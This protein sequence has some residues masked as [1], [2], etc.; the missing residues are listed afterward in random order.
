MWFANLLYD[1]TSVAQS[2]FVVSVA[3]AL[4]LG[5]GNLTYKG[6]GLGIA[7]CLFSGLLMGHLGF[8]VN[9]EFLEFMREFGLILFVYTVGLQVG[10]G[11]LSA[12]RAQ[13]LRLNL[14]AAA[15][16][17]IGSFVTWVI[18]T[19]NDMPAAIAVG[20]FSGATT[21]TPS[22]GAAQSLL[23][24][25]LGPQNPSIQSSGMAYAVAYPFGVIGIIIVM[26]GLRIVFR[27]N[28]D[29]EAEAYGTD[30]R[31]ITEPLDIINIEVMNHNLNGLALDK[32]PGIEDLGVVISRVMSR[33]S[34]AGAG[35]ANCA[36]SVQ[37][38][39]AGVV[40]HEGDI[41]HAVGT[42]KNL[43]QLE[44]IVGRKTDID[45]KAF[46]SGYTS[47]RISIS[48]TSIAG[49]PIDDLG[50]VR[51]GGAVFTRINRA[52]LEFTPTSNVRL[53]FGDVVT[54]VGSE[55]ILRDTENELGNS[56]K[57]LGHPKILP[58]FIGIAI[59]V[60]IGSI[61]FAIPGSP[62]PIK[63]G[64]AG[65][66][67]LVAILFSI[68]RHLG[69][70]VWHLPQ[71]SNL[72]LRE[73]GIVLFLT[74]VGIKSGG[75]FIS[76][77]MTGP[78]LEWMGWGAIITL[79]PLVIVAVFARVALKMNFLVICGLVAGAST[80]PPAL[81]FANTQGQSDAPSL[82]YSTV[83]PLAMILR[84]FCAQALVLLLR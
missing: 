61:P 11:F 78:G 57:E 17:L 16:V 62:I 19:L 73:M 72:V 25:I 32:I 82:T 23:K 52:G 44:L 46:D 26:L 13:G 77:L 7:G 66:P 33:A 41:I 6:I 81:S 71:S 35:G 63:L 3:A 39:S 9:P 74:S 80:D 24:D 70:V 1:S 51:R 48:K 5:L 49:K 69:P 34:G 29:H 40:I 22:L 2:V 20:L 10:P 15:I 54:V 55:A 58:I 38:A 45:V 67:L 59:G 84:V 75:S 18:G 30:R 60:L 65:G 56:V 4:G 64:L 79:A 50:S 42:P 12:L 53:Q 31:V 28:V 47:R 21:N 8:N 36:T 27:L 76:T 14:L 83:Y 68:L 37:I 43:H